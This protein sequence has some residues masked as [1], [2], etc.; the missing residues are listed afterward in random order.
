[1]TPPNTPAERVREKQGMAE[2]S[3]EIAA[4]VLRVSKDDVLSL[5]A[6]GELK[7]KR[8]DPLNSPIIDYSSVIDLIARM[9]S[10]KPDNQQG[11]ES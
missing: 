1:M 5:V 11:S 3:V 4:R 10:R 7:S 9:A 6:S 8:L 2:V